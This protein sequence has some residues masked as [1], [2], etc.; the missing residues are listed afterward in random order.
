MSY[1]CE[2]L[3]VVLPFEVYA[4]ETV[5]NDTIK[6]YYRNTL[7]AN[8]LRERNHEIMKDYCRVHIVLSLRVSFSITFIRARITITHSKSLNKA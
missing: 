8:L 6:K 7:A 2:Y 3:L 5:K 1:H 4:S